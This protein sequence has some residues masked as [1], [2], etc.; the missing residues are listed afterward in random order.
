MLIKIL[1][2]LAILIIILIAVAI[3]IIY[4]AMPREFYMLYRAFR[5]SDDKN[6]EGAINVFDKILER[7]PT[8]HTVWEAKGEILH[9]L[10]KYEEALEIYDKGLACKDINAKKPDAT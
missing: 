9:K 4:K 1:L 8:W 5:L 7:K 2:I 3:Y 6:Y 10:G